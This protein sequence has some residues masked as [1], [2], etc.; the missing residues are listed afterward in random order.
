MRAAILCKYSNEIIKDIPYVY[1]FTNTFKGFVSIAQP[2][3]DRFGCFPVFEKV[4]NIGL[5]GIP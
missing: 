3:L 2:S 4:R 5:Q 1:N